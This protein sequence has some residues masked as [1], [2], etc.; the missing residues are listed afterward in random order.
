[1][2]LNLPYMLVFEIIF[3]K[4]YKYELDELAEQI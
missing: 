2:Q 4:L 1:M 3:L